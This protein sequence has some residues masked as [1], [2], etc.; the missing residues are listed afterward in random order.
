MINLND[1]LT[2]KQRFGLLPIHLTP[3][4]D[5]NSFIMLH[6]GDGDFCLK[7]EAIHG[8]SRDRD[9][10][11]SCAWSSNTKNFVVLNDSTVTIYNWKKDKPETIPKN[12]VEENID[13]FYKYLVSISYKSETDI[14]PFIID[15]FKQFRNFTQ[16]DKQEVEA[17]NFL[18]VLLAGIEEDNINFDKWELSRNIEIPQNFDQYIT[19]L[20]EGLNIKPNLNIHPNLDII[21]RHS[22][23]ILFQEAQKEVFFFDRQK[24]LWGDFSNKND[25]KK[26]WYSSIYYIPP[27]V[28]RS[29]VENA[30]RKID[31][32]KP[33]LKIFDP[34]CGSS[35]FLTEVLKQLRENG[36]G[37]NIQIVG[38][39]S[40]EI[41][42]NISKFRLNYEKR[43]IWQD[44]LNYN[45]ILVENSLHEEWSNDYD[46]IL[47]NPPFV[48]WEQMDNDSKGAVKEVL[49]SNIS[50]KAKPNQ[51]IA[52][53]FKS[54]QSLND[55]G[56]IGC[57]IP[58]SFLTL[59][60][61]Q[62]LRNEVYDLISISLLGK[63]GN[64]VFENTLTDISLV[65]GHKPKTE[66]IPFILWTANERGTVQNSLRNLRKMYCSG[67][68]TIVDKDCSIYQPSSFPIKENW[69]PISAQKYEVL[70]TL[71]RLVYEKKLVKIGDIFDV[72]T[73][74]KTGHNEI[75]KISETEYH[76]LPDGEKSFFKRVVD[77]QSI[78]NGKIIISNYIWYPYNKEG[79]LIKTEQELN[80]KIHSFYKV[81]LNVIKDRK[82]K[83]NLSWWGLASYCPW[84]IKK[85]KEPR[86]ISTA[87][88]KSDFFAFDG[89]SDSFAFDKDGIF[90]IEGGYA[91]FPKKKFDDIN[92]YYFYLALFSSP[93]FYEL[94]SIYSNQYIYG[95]DLGKKYTKDIPIPDIQNI[96]SWEIIHSSSYTSLVEIGKELSE[97]SFHYKTILDD[98]LFKSFYPQPQIYNYG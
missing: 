71:E 84:L 36:Y 44:K 38:W 65:I 15:I 68:S 48:S 43:T 46:L 5:E 14:I 2:W 94:L 79:L 54:I 34:A 53:L 80:Q 77:N 55:N 88:G 37:G 91:W 29:I 21:L 67:S 24:H 62:K 47:M 25:S 13:K 52:F 70:K 22:S 58:S 83:E 49:G 96:H 51:A 98:I 16:G 26:N 69:Q 39:D 97:G 45:I 27:Y 23:G 81:K 28:C 87:F 19:K 10:Y 33:L 73:G 4:H 8:T 7:T 32:N 12:Q 76:E 56:I 9:F 61:Y 72:K 6:G 1:T 89:K 35:E 86:L 95:W 50:S 78:K 42:I 66:N 90:Y 82:K 60:T 74:I 30:I 40:S 85:E 17:L 20:K 93:F 11:Y 3:I 92:H 59:D 75:F 64:F 31:K 57:I 18:F 41:A 63:L